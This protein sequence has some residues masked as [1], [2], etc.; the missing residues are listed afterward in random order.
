MTKP[1][2]EKEDSNAT[3]RYPTKYTSRR[4]DDE[5]GVTLRFPLNRPGTGN[6]GR[7]GI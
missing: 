7:I 4:D 2:E 3:V 1:E 5:S 6:F